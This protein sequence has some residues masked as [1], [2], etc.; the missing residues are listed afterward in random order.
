MERHTDLLYL[1]KACATHRQISIQYEVDIGIAVLEKIY[2]PTYKG[3]ELFTCP[4]GSIS[5]GIVDTL[6]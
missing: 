2:V 6:F 5:E 1:F 4:T 3:N